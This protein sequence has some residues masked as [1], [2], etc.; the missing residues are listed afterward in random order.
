[1]RTLDGQKLPD[2]RPGVEPGVLLPAYPSIYLSESVHSYWI[3]II[4]IIY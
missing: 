4:F 3:S 1:V 2:W